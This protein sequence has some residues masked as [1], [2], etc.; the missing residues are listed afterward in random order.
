[1]KIV[2]LNS[3]SE[4][5]LQLETIQLLYPKMT[6]EKYEAFLQEMTTNHYKQVAVFEGD[7]CVGISGFWVNTKLWTGKYLEIDNF[8]VN[9]EFRSQ[10]IGKLICEKIDQIAKDLNCNCIV[11]DAFTQNFQAHRFYYNLGYVPRGFHFIKTINENG[12]S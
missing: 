7:K 12:F 4:M 6:I 3:V 11:L 8:V 10:G 9:P 5:L 2:V 1:M